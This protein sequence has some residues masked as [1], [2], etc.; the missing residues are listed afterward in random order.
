MKPLMKR[1]TLLMVPALVLT[2]ALNP[3]AN[4]APRATEGSKPAKAG[5]AAKSGGRAVAVKKKAPAAKAKTCSVSLR[6][7]TERAM[8]SLGADTALEVVTN[9]NVTG[10]QIESINVPLRLEVRDPNEARAAEYA[11]LARERI[12]AFVEADHADPQAHMAAA[13]SLT[14]ELTNLGGAEQ[15]LLS[16]DFMKEPLKNMKEADT[17]QLKFSTSVEGFVKQIILLDPK[18]NELLNPGFVGRLFGQSREKREQKYFDEVVTGRQALEEAIKVVKANAA[19]LAESNQKMK[20]DRVAMIELEL[21]LEDKIAELVAMDHA[22]VDH[23]ERETT[24]DDPMRKYLV[25]EILRPIRTAVQ[26]FQLMSQ[27]LNQALIQNYANVQRNIELMDRSQRAIPRL[28]VVL[29]TAIGNKI[30]VNQQ[31]RTQATLNFIDKSAAEIQLQTAKD[32][33]KTGEMIRSQE[34]VMA[35]IVKTMTEVA[36]IVEK[37]NQAMEAY[38]RESVDKMAAITKDLGALNERAR[39]AAQRLATAESARAGMSQSEKWALSNRDAREL[40]EQRNVINEMAGVLSQGKKLAK[41]AQAGIMT[42]A[43]AAMKLAPKR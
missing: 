19:T 7:G 20:K 27:S 28:T 9:A 29:S 41:S 18:K 25:E 22:I 15:S 4:A 1:S 8:E 35:D 13:D 36:D 30:V 23:I 38:K 14:A 40:A 6:E 43:Q 17:S 24:P 11:Q 10:I 12:E 5:A 34:A 33:A 2:F 39:Q 42:A 32:F 37:E 31:A 26:D 3:V 16:S 21:L